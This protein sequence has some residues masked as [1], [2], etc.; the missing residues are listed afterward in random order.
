MTEPHLPDQHGR[1]ALITGA[2]SGLGL[3]TA[4]A[5]A[6]AGATVFLACRNPERAAAALDQ[7][8]A[9][10]TGDA[11]R[12]VALDLS[13]LDSVATAADEVAGL[14]D[15]L[16][17]LVNNAGIMAVPKSRTAQGFESQFGVN[18]LGHYALTGHLLPTLLAAPAPRVV[19]VASG[20]HRAGRMHWDDLDAT[21]G[22]Q[23]WLRYGQSKLANLL[24]SAEL[25]R[26][27]G[28]HGT[29]L[30]GVAA[31]PGYAAT[32]LTHNGP[33]GGGRRRFMDG[34]TRV[35]DKLFAQSAAMGARPQIH[36][37]TSPDVV[38]NDYFG[39]DGLLE[40]RG[41]GVKRVGRTGRAADPAAAERLWAISE[42]KTGVV[43]PWPDRT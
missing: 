29:T 6:G 22:Y 15:H 7:V 28:V 34:L 12:T 3:E 19:S 41:R 27:A 9:V 39:P 10:A 1:I 37:A 24:F 30:I 26:L 17:V 8:A 2:N 16:D 38:G 14:V 4:Q 33:G 35:G 42:E 31:H 36:A 23:S 5:L 20:A 40:Q 25:N 21:R 43:Y 11:P 32:S 13:D 18:H